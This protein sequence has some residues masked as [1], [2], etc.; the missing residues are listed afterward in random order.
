MAREHCASPKLRPSPH[1]S[2]L[3]VYALAVAACET[4]TNSDTSAAT[5]PRERTSFNANWHFI[6]DD[7]AGAAG[8]LAYDTIK[9]QLLANAASPDFV[10]R[11]TPDNLGLGQD[12]SYAQPGFDDSSWRRLNLPHDW[13]IEGGFDVN[14]NPATGRLPY[15]AP[16]GTARR[17]PSPP[18][19]GPAHLSRRGRRDVLRRCL[20]QRQISAAGPT[21]TLP[22]ELD[23]TPYV[24]P[25]R[26]TSSP[27]GST[28][29]TT[30]RA[31]IPAAAST[32]MSGWSR[33]SRFTSAQWGVYVT[34]P[35][36]AQGAATVN[37]EVNVENDSAHRGRRHGQ[38]R[39]CTNSTPRAITPATRVADRGCTDGQ[40]RRRRHATRRPRRITVAEAAALEPRRSPICYV[41]VTTRRARRPG[42]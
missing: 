18:A 1:C 36:V 31:G 22:G 4:T 13:G 19:T 35:E 37:V 34:T 32:A 38:H 30:P 41:A 26:R 28:T 5:R 10:V 6:K 42:R 14:L 12:V 33:P 24:K 40:D 29:R 20:A 9:P 7:P 11:A 15:W 8:A 16:R 21:A 39:N 3:P 25:A 2:W 27:S 23:L 17:S